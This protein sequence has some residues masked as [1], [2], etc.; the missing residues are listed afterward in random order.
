M[1]WTTPE[2]VEAIA[3]KTTVLP[4]TE[5]IQSFIDNVERQIKRYF[6]KI[7]ERI[8]E[9]EI[10]VP[11]IA[12]N[13][14]II[15]NE[16]LAVEG[17]YVQETQSYGNAVSASRTLA[18][19]ARTSL[20]LAEEDFA[21]FAPPVTNDAAYQINMAPNANVSDF[22]SYDGFWNPTGYERVIG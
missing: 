16:Y 11:D 2:D 22:H 13:V 4:T 6:P 5:K 12:D 21:L 14:S 1:S 20:R 10:T 19:G 9:G 18:S 15:L 7:E 3:S 17:P 8:L